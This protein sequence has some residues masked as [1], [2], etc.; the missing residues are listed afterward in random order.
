MDDCSDDEALILNLLE[1]QAVA[2]IVVAV[3]FAAAAADTV[4]VDIVVNV[5]V[6]AG[7]DYFSVVCFFA[8]NM[9]DVVAAAAVA[10]QHILA[11]HLVA[12][13]DYHLY[14]CSAMELVVV[15]DVDCLI[16]TFLEA[17]AAA[18]EDNSF[19]LPDLVAAAAAAASS[20]Y[21]AVH[22]LSQPTANPHH[23]YSLRSHLDT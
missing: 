23:L 13:I 10:Y 20:A 12:Y 3:V 17:A 5:D 21:S 1:D 9:D 11:A 19:D 2:D 16:H 22:P 7:V 4:D 18:V 8:V 14:C 15:A 6:A